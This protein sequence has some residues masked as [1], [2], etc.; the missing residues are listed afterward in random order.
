MDVSKDQSGEWD[1]WISR[2]NRYGGKSVQ[3]NGLEDSGQGQIV[4]KSKRCEMSSSELRL[5]VK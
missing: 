1:D 5:K 3:K 4:N 2:R